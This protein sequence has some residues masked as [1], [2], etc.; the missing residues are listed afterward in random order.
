[1]IGGKVFAEAVN[2][3]NSSEQQ[4]KFPCEEDSAKFC[5]DAKLEKNGI[6]E[7]MEK[8]RAKKE[9]SAACLSHIEHMEQREPSKQN[10]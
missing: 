8:H 5:K 3:V 9:L 1:M 10:Q 6:F 2:S 7:C 4:N